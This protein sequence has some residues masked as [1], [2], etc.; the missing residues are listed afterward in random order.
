MLWGC[1]APVEL[2]KQT[3]TIELGKDVYANPALYV[4][5]GKN[6]HTED[7][8][9]VSVSRGIAKKENRF[10]SLGKEYLVV[11]EY[12]FKNQNGLAGN[13]VPGSRSRIHSRL[14]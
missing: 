1:A 10:I 6:Y 12:D 11:G 3:F 4:K 14:P 8:S 5:D 2:Q 7:M 9:V 13:P